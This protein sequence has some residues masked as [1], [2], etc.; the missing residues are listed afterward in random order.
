MNSILKEDLE[1]IYEN[2]KDSAEKFNGS[3][4][5]ITGC[6]GFLGY[7]F[8][9]FFNTYKAELKMLART[10]D[11]YNKQNIIFKFNCN[12]GTTNR[13]FVIS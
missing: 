9:N 4:I 12:N 11:K 10:M 2:I 3:N 8:L 7:Y 1:N 5:F 13:N 6:C